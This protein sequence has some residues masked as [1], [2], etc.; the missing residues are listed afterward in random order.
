[1]K[2]IQYFLNV[3]TD[4]SLIVIDELC[5]STSVEEGTA[6]AMAVCERLMKTPAFL[7]ITTHFKFMTKLEELHYNVKRFV[8]K[9][10]KIILN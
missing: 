9:L 10:Q 4:N 6:I 2:E 1:M 5:R 7:F 8:F 3:L